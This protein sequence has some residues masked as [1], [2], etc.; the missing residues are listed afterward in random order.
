MA[1]SDQ[2]NRYPAVLC[3]SVFYEKLVHGGM[4]SFPPLPNPSNQYCLYSILLGGGGGG[5]GH[6]ESKVLCPREHNTLTQPRLKHKCLDLEIQRANHSAT[7]SPTQNTSYKGKYFLY[8]L[9]LEGN[10]NSLFWATLNTF[11]GAKSL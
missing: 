9:E 10:N 1:C 8:F 3:G 6:S 4:L 5:E 11:G 7:T 2:K